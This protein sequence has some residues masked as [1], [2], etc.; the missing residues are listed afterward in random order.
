MYAV[1]TSL[2]N[3]QI[4]EGLQLAIADYLKAHINVG[5]ME[6]VYEW[7]RQLPFSDICQLTDVLEGSIVRC[8]TRLDETCKEVRNAARIIGD[9]SLYT[10]MEQASQMIK[11][12]I[13]F[14]SSLYVG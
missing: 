8:I 7:A 3:I 1:A 6:V 2:A 10:K 13:V 5:L 4:E 12:D 14:A 9:T 11:R